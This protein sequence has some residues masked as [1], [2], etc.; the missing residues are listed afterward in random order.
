LLVPRA[1]KDAP[2]ITIPAPGQAVDYFHADRLREVV[3]TELWEKR[4]R[5]SFDGMRMEIG[6]CYRTTRAPG[7]SGRGTRCLVTEE[8]AASARTR[9]AS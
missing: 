1:A 6:P 9:S 5:F 2:A 8:P 4:E 7:S 3:P